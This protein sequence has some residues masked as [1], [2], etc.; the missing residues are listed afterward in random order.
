[1]FPTVEGG[2]CFSGNLCPSSKKLSLLP[3]GCLRRSPE[4]ERGDTC[5][6]FSDLATLFSFYSKFSP[7]VCSVFS[8]VIEVSFSSSSSSIRM[9]EMDSV[10]LFLPCVLSSPFAVLKK[11]EGAQISD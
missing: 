7:G 10:E 1:M 4:A 5:S 8:L 3:S 6:R 2:V 11:V 9:Y